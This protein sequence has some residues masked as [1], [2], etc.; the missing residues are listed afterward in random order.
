[1]KLTSRTILLL[2]N[3]SLINP[4]IVLKE[5]NIL[6]TIDPN[7]TILA[8][9]EISEV[10]PK[11]CAIYNLVTFLG[12][13]SLVKDPDIQF[14]DDHLT[15]KESSTVVKIRYGSSSLI[16]TPPDKSIPV[17]NDVQFKLPTITFQS[18]M[19]AQGTMQLPEISVKGDS[20]GIFLSALDSKNTTGDSFSIKVGEPNEHTFNFIFNPNNL[21][22]INED[23]DAT[24]TSKGLMYLKGDRLEY[25]V[26]A[27]SNSTFT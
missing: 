11:E 26:P 18:I 20:N 4:A 25:W 2:K 14:H 12:T 10:W 7:K 21:K 27:E 3:Y 6:S 24:I 1:M 13:L 22:F 16:A 19:K 15:I 17:T 9:A 23:Y 5:G 8:K